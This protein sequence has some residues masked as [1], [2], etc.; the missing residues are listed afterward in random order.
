M[1]VARDWVIRKRVRRS[2]IVCI[3]AAN[4][5]EIEGGI[6]VTYDLD[7]WCDRNSKGYTARKVQWP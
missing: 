7:V 4:V 1:F 6:E 2:W 3:I 5:S